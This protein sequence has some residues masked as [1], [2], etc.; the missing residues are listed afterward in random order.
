MD[1]MERRIKNTQIFEDTQERYEED[2]VLKAAI[3]ASIQKQK[4]ILENDRV[5]IPK[6][7]FPHN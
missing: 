6:F 2:V 1:I 5:A 7:Y 4:L 3:E